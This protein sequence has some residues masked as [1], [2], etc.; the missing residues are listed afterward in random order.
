MTHHQAKGEIDKNG[1]DEADAQAAEKAIVWNERQTHFIV[2]LLAQEHDLVMHAVIP[3]SLDGGLDLYCFGLVIADTAIANRELC[4]VPDEGESNDDFENYELVMFTRHRI[5]L[6]DASDE[7]TPSGQAHYQIKVILNRLRP[8]SAEGAL[9]AF[10]TCEFRPEIETVGVSC[11]IFDDYG[12]RP[13]D[14]PVG[15]L[16]AIRIHR[17]EMDFARASGVENLKFKLKKA[18]YDPCSDL[19]LPAVAQVA[20]DSGDKRSDRKECEPEDG[21]VEPPSQAIWRWHAAAS[22]TADSASSL[23]AK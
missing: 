15:L 19:C 23:Q 9:N 10:E 20:H 4:E 21:L 18:G 13:A 1:E 5:S 14:N 2:E 16:A 6:D 11:L 22:Q 12:G 3:Y 8:Y 17:S 7:S